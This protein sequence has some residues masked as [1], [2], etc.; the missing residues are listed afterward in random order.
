MRRSAAAL[1]VAVGLGLGACAGSRDEPRPT[2]APSTSGGTGTS[3]RIE[4]LA[5]T[6]AEEK[7]MTLTCDPAGGDHPDPGAACDALFAA[8]PRIFEPVPQDQACTEIFGGPQLA[9]VTGTVSGDE[10]EAA[11]S[12]ADG[13]EI[14]RWDTLGTAFFDVPLQ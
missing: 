9:S 3:L 1:L 4:V 12:R 14:E 13:C 6:G 11:F 7:V 10:V 5:D 8:G 2:P